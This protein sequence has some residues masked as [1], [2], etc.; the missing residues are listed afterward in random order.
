MF[1]KGS[2]V[3][4]LSIDLLLR[5]KAYFDSRNPTYGQSLDCRICGKSIHFL[6]TYITLDPATKT[7][8]TYY[9]VINDL[10][11]RLPISGMYE[12]KISQKL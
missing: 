1:E 9:E 4:E 12:E 11:E 6:A 10:V 5:L 3:P 7:L 8:E 2:H